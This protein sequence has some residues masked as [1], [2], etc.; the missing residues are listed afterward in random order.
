MA[1]AFQIQGV[2]EAALGAAALLPSVALSLQPPP[3]ETRADV[4]RLQSEAGP[5]APSDKVALGTEAGE[6]SLP[7]IVAERSRPPGLNRSENAVDERQRRQKLRLLPRSG[8]LEERERIGR[9]LDV[10]A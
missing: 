4:R 8:W 6:T 7:T 1:D 10:R 9:H 3:S 2:R 5:I